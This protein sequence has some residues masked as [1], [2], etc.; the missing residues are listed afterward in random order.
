MTKTTHQDR[1]KA[2]ATERD[3]KFL[4]EYE[5]LVKQGK[6][7]PE[8]AKHF[9]FASVRVLQGRRSRACERLGIKVEAIVPKHVQ[10]AA[11]RRLSVPVLAD[12]GYTLEELVA[13]RKRR[14]QRKKE[15]EDCRRKIP[16]GVPI[17]GPFAIW[18]FG[19]PHVD[20]DGTDLEA[21]E[22]H[23]KTVNQTEG[24]YGA[25]LGDSSNNWVGRLARLY[26]EQGTSAKEAWQL[27]EWFV[28]LVGDKWMFMIGG[29]HDCL[30]MKTEALTRRGWI[31]YEEIRGDDLVLGMNRLTGNLE[32]QPILKKFDRENDEKMI[33]IDRAVDM[34]VTA[35]HRVLHSRRDWKRIWAPKYEY[36][37]ADSLPA[38]FR[39]PVSGFVQNTGTTL[40]DAQIELAGWFLTDGYINPDE[41]RA[42]IY[43]SKDPTRI[44]ELLDACGLEYRE[45][46]RERD[47]TH[48]CGRELKKPPLPQREFRLTAEATRELLGWVPEKGRLPFWCDRMTDH[49]FEVLLEGLIAGDGTWDGVEDGNC[50]VLHGTKEFLESV[51]I[52][53]LQHGWRAFLSVAR[54]KDYR[55]NLTR[56]TFCEFDRAVV[57]REEEPDER[58]WCLTVPFGNFMV[59][60]NGKPHITGNCWSGSGDPLIWIS[61]E[62]NTLYEASEARIEVKPPQGRAFTINAR[63][64]F[65]GNSQWNPTHAVMKA[66]QLGVRDD[67]LV[68]GHKHTTGYQPLKCP[69]T[70]KIMHCLQVASYKI[71]DRYARE[72]GFRDQAISPGAMIVVDPH[73][74]NDAAF[75]QVFHDFDLGVEF[76]K[77]LRAKRK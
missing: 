20:D 19:D 24:L 16:I 30:D 67:V 55:L 26:G 70:K 41:S 69:E 48:V 59:R 8:V 75:I 58:V 9:G 34:R 56:A 29:N 22:Y 37:R 35:G 60:R 47:I 71:Y 27:V 72:K 50:A 63:H 23:A 39:I 31:K 15:A 36:A 3:K 18:F 21:L 10:K 46:V 53:A 49:Q 38:R 45:S 1:L 57:V 11:E 43:Q 5:K 17:E 68:C 66:A 64:D 52:V 2:E 33:R 32:W 65:A 4:A 73:A 14:F 76:L 54:E 28:R 13:L 51:Q 62:Q 74:K 6:T 7:L 25:N 12:D 42:S 61:R 77:F 40:S 44:R